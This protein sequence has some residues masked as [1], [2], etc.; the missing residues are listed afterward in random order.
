VQRTSL[1]LKLA[2][3]LLTVPERLRPS[4]QVSVIEQSF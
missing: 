4:S 2:E 3:L 1:S